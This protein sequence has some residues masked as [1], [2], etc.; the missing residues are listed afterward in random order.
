LSI[1]RYD[2]PD[3]TAISGAALIVLA[4]EA[5]SLHAPWMRER[6]GDYGAQVRN[7]LQNGLAYTGRIS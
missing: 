4:V 2:P 5:T 7:R 6:A 3:A 1:A